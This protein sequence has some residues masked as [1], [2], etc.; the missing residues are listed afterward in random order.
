MRFLMLVAALHNTQIFL[1]NPNPK[2]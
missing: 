1:F 2:Q